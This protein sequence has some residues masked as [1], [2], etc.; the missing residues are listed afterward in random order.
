MCPLLHKKGMSPVTET[1][2]FKSDLLALSTRSLKDQECPRNRETK[3]TISSPVSGPQEDVFPPANT[4]EA[5]LA[6]GLK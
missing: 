6:R 1:G 3:F 5:W 4:R 2:L